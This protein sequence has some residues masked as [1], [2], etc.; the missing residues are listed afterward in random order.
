[1]HVQLQFCKFGNKKVISVP[2]SNISLIYRLPL[3]KVFPGEPLEH[4]IYDAAHRLGTLL[5]NCDVYKCP[6]SLVDMA[7]GYYN[8]PSPKVDLARS[9]WAMFSSRFG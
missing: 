2:F 7:Q 1:M 5:E 6:L 8:A 4:S 9:P 3:S